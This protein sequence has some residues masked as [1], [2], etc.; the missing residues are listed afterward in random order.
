M[1][2]FSKFCEQFTSGLEYHDELNPKLWKNDALL[3]DVKASLDVIAQNFIKFLKIDDSK[4]SDIVLTGSSANFNYTNQSDLDIHV[5]VGFDDDDH[6]SVGLK[7]MD[8]FTTAKT[9]WNLK[10][11]I[12]VHGYQ[13]EAYVQPASEKFNWNAGVFSLRSQSW[14]QH[15][16]RLDVDF[17]SPEIERK[18]QSIID[19]IN[20]LVDGDIQNTK[21]IKDLKARIKQLRSDGIADG[22]EFGLSNSV[23]KAIR[24]SGAIGKLSD[25]ASSLEDH[26]LSLQ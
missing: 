21:M 8:A 22:G 19:Q 5:I 10:H 11:K 6:N 14:I 2:T 7:T 15:P 3:P 4:I 20:H 25:F 1:K 16:R 23:F 26:Q 17:G 18:A 12:T 24:N 13:I 9:L